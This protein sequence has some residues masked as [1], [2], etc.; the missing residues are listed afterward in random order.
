MTYQ[1]YYMPKDMEDNGRGFRM[2]DI[3][4]YEMQSPHEKDK[5]GGSNDVERIE[6]LVNRIF[7]INEHVQDYGTS[8]W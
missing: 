7:T 5:C 6:V 1:I 4:Y 2:F 8:N 3:E